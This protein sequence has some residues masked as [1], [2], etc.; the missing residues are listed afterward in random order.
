MSGFF[1]GSRA[2]GRTIEASG[3]GSDRSQHGIARET[4]HPFLIREQARS[5][6]SFCSV[7]EHF[8]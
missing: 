7:L 8:I 3:S 5:K 1:P 2:N 4:R 6:I